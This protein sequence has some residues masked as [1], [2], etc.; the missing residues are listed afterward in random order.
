L[1]IDRFCLAD[2]RSLIQ[3][4]R[5]TSAL[6]KKIFAPTLTLILSLGLSPT[7]LANAGPGP[8]AGG[9]YY[10]GGTDGKYQAAAYGNNISGIIGFTI[11]DG[12]PAV[13]AIPSAS[14]GAGGGGA[15]G[16]AGSGGGPGALAASNAVQA[17]DA[18]QNYFLMFVE[19]RTYSGLAA[20]SVNPVGKKVTGTLLGAQPDFGVITNTSILLSVQTLPPTVVTNVTNTVSTNI[21]I[22]NVGGALQT[23]FFV[24][25]N[26]FSNVVT[27]GPTF[28]TNSNT[29]NQVTPDPIPILNRG[30]SG[31]FQAKLKNNQAYMTFSGNGQL[32]TPSQLQTI[33]VVTNAAGNMTGG[34]IETDMVSFQVDGLR[35]SFITVSPSAATTTPAN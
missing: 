32:S 18:T 19:G 17:F 9:A 16:G 20:G 22:T 33:N 12:G 29:V 2:H 21:S 6:M 23:N 26:F 10:P 4:S 35:T 13:T 1:S 3:R 14:G 5:T 28:L 15:G 11:R 8:W 25:T 7:A 34:T 24:S 31:A 27:V 30:L